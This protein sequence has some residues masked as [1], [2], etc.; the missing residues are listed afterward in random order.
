MGGGEACCSIEMASKL[1]KLL[2]TFAREWQNRQPMELMETSFSGNDFEAFVQHLMQPGMICESGMTIVRQEKWH[3]F[4]RCVAQAKNLAEEKWA[5]QIDYNPERFIR[6]S[7]Y[8][9]LQQQ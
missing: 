1:A 6:C 4:D 8:L 9:I 5:F 2:A 7:V 3:G